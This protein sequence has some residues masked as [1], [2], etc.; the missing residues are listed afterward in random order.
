MS[1]VA[2]VLELIK[3]STLSFDLELFG[4]N[5]AALD[6]ALCT[7]ATFTMR[8]ALDGSNILV[9]KS[10]APDL[11]LTIDIPNKKL[12]ATLTQGEA[13]ALVPESYVAD[14]ALKIG[15]KWV[16]TDLFNVDVL[17]SFS[18]HTS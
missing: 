18:A 15:G 1:D 6:I 5:D 17:P 13:D 8:K 2:E 4:S 10:I 14:V 9:R 11:N 7:E 12:T 3:G 16:H